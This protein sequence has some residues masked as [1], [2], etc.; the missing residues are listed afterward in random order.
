MAAQAQGTGQTSLSAGQGSPKLQPTLSV[1]KELA[2]LGEFDLL[3]VMNEGYEEP[4]ADLVNKKL[5]K[6]K[7]KAGDPGER[8]VDQL[9]RRCKDCID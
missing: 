8:K 7:E 4:A 2:E 5:K 1:E 3:E 6:K 9:S